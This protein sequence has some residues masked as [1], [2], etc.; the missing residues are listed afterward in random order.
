MSKDE[1]FYDMIFKIVLI[2]DSG[3][4]K[5]NIMSRY[6]KDE[7]SFETRTTVGVEFGAKKIE[8]SGARIKAQIWDTAG[9]ERYKS[10]A[11]AYYKGSKAALVVFD[12]TNEESFLNVDKWL[13]EVRKNG[14]KDIS[15]III[16]NKSDL[17]DQ[18]KIS[19]ERGQNKA[20]ENCN[21]IYL[22]LVCA[23]LETSAYQSVNIDKAFKIMIE[24]VD[25]KY[26]KQFME[27]DDIDFGGNDNPISLNS[28]PPKNEEN[29]CAC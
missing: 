21:F 29:K 27:L 1:E 19:K 26:R 14:E 10:V 7:F 5:S 15:I 11:N 17:E 28:Q 16:G 18:R 24:E 2:G 6:L 22:C 13:S 9:Q 4:G 8:L 3:V 12:L 20:E 23:F 25:R